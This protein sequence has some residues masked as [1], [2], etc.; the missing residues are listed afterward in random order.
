ME[1]DLEIWLEKHQNIKII[2]VI[3]II[4]INT[5]LFCFFNSLH[6]YSSNLVSNYTKQIISK[7]STDNLYLHAYDQEQQSAVTSPVLYLFAFR[8]K[9]TEWKIHG[10]EGTL[11]ADK[12]K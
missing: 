12:K 2:A 7:M 4:N 1:I 6:Y 11:F 5:Y 9:V 8:S 3:I 10:C